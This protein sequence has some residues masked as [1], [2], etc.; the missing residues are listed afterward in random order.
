MTNKPVPPGEPM[1]D[2]ATQFDGNPNALPTENDVL[3]P[4]DDT[5]P[6]LKKKEGPKKDESKNP[7][8]R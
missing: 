7:P 8:A 1:N 5:P 4:K 2:R 6:F 3:G